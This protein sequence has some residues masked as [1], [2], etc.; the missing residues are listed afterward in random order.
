MTNKRKKLLLNILVGG[1][2]ACLA[3]IA[4]FYL[5]MYLGTDRP[6][7][8]R[9]ISAPFF[10]PFLLSKPFWELFWP[11]ENYIYEIMSFSLI[12]YF[13]CGSIMGLVY[14]LVKRRI[15]YTICLSIMAIFI[16]I[17][18]ALYL[19]DSPRAPQVNDYY[20]LDRQ[21]V[22]T[23]L[24]VRG[25][26]DSGVII[27]QM[28]GGPAD[29]AIRYS[30]HPAYRDLESRYAVA[31]WDQP[32]AGNS[33]WLTPQREIPV[34]E[35]S[36]ALDEVVTLLHRESPHSKLF[37]LAHSFGA[38]PVIKYLSEYPAAQEAVTGWIDVDGAHNELL[39]FTL[40]AQWLENRATTRL[41]ESKFDSAEEKQ[42]WQDAREYA[43]THQ[44]YENWYETELWDNYIG[45]AGGYNYSPETDA[46]MGGIP[47]YLLGRA[48]FF[49]EK[50]NLRKAK[51]VFRDVF[52]TDYTPALN[53]ITIP[54]LVLWGR[55]DGAVVV[56]MAQDVYENVE[57]EEKTL[58]IFEQSAH[59]PMLEEPE[60]YVQAVTTFVEEYT[61]Q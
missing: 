13:L 25:N 17:P 59:N 32:G 43:Q 11:N 50:E 57:T 18:T 49:L 41:Q 58:V 38:E 54:T 20:R 45:P 22:A 28:H 8:L 47:H 27:L 23:P 10:I 14:S 7:I 16:L 39:N 31:Y 33:R 2:L 44:Q 46:V 24:W 4:F 52:Q 9:A 53:Q 6:F 30:M 51:Y 60:K 29:T 61:R 5:T 21:G 26:I 40:A 37:I 15:F 12:F 1:I 42:F 55:H 3:A 36:A 34:S 19:Y 35:I 48:N 56:D